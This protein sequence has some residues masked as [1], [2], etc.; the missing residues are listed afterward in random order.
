[1]VVLGSSLQNFRMKGDHRFQHEKLRVYHE[2]V[3]FSDMVDRV[4]A[5]YGPNRPLMKNLKRSSESVLYNI[6]EAAAEYRPLEKGRIYRIALREA[7][8]SA[9]ALAK[10]WRRTT[11]PLIAEAI[12]MDRGICAML[13]GLA[14]KMDRRA[15]TARD[16]PTPPRP[17]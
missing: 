4:V 3:E 10:E 17:P 5:K 12:A 14:R 2:A 6:A 7:E 13:V 1:M 16:L 9:A 11:D 15:A 8:E